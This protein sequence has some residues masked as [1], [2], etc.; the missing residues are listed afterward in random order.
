MNPLSIS[1]NIISIIFLSSMETTSSWWHYDVGKKSKRATKFILCD[2]KS[3]YKQILVYI[4][5][6][7]LMMI[8]ELTDMSFVKQ[9]KFPSSHFN[10]LEYNI[11]CNQYSTSSSSHYQT[12]H[13]PFSN[14]LIRNYYFN[15]LPWPWNALLQTDL[16][17]SVHTI[18]FKIYQV[19]WNY[20]NNYFVSND[21]CPSHHCY[22]WS[23]CLS[24]HHILTLISPWLL[25]FASRSSMFYSHFYS[26]C[27]TPTSHMYTNK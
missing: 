22:P 24:V 13:S 7:P 5:L 20:F 4:Q 16:S 11:S 10:I 9:V 12:I 17:E 23:K 27:F 19:F 2:Y 18:K 14:N 3:E 21:S 15:R 25:A 26:S 1:G 6:L 8:L